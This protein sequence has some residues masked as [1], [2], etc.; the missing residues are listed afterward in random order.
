MLSAISIFGFFLFAFQLKYLLLYGLSYHYVL[1]NCSLRC[2][3]AFTFAVPNYEF[4]LFT[5][6]WKG[7]RFHQPIRVVLHSSPR[8]CAPIHVWIASTQRLRST[9]VLASRSRWYREL[10]EPLTIKKDRSSCASRVPRRWP[11]L[12]RPLLTDLIVPICIDET[13]L[14]FLAP[15]FFHARALMSGVAYTNRWPFSPQ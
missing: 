13:S 12:R 1:S 10:P 7:H 14:A 8:W 6:S 15:C 9:V 11:P 4:F 2:V 5:V 3:S